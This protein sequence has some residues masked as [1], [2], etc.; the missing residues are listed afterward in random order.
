MG[1]PGGPLGPYQGQRTTRR[2]PGPGYYKGARRV[3]VG[4]SVPRAPWK[5]KG[6][7]GVQWDCQGFPGLRELPGVQ[8]EPYQRTNRSLMGLLGQGPQG[9]ARGPPGSITGPE[10][11][12]GQGT[13]SA[14]KGPTRAKR[15]TKMPHGPRELTGT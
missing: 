5:Y 9:T 11:Y 1:L 2:L 15:N 14:P 8:Q 6:P 4:L 7:P 3:A 13:T 10:D 12:Q